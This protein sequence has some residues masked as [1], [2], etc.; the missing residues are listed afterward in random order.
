MSSKYV[1]PSMRSHP[2]PASL[3][4]TSLPAK[5]APKLVPATLASITSNGEVPAV[6]L[7]MKNM[8]LERVSIH[9]PTT[10][11]ATLS[12]DDF[13]SLGKSSK[14]PAIVSKLV[15]NPSVTSS[16]TTSTTTAAK[17]AMNFA[18]LSREW[19]EKQKEEARIAA[20]EAEKERMRLQLEM[21]AKEKET[22][23]FR[24]QRII[25]LPSVKKTNLMEQEQYNHYH[26]DLS[27]EEP[28]ESPPEDD[29]EEEDEE[30]EYNSQWDGRRYRDEL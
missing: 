30:E 5:E 19:A 27:E 11:A 8:T 23:E 14:A 16:T 22:T 15:T 12:A 9:K 29:Y 7:S 3:I 13:P 4:N 25:A 21:Q 2:S 26:D 6:T 20:E 10:K 18:A 24:H 28:Y 17:P 1:P